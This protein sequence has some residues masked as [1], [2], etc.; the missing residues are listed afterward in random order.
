ME[1]LELY[2]AKL[3]AY[4][5]FSKKKSSKKTV[6]STSKKDGKKGKDEKFEIFKD[7][8][9]VENSALAAQQKTQKTEENLEANDKIQ[10]S[11]IPS[12]KLRSKK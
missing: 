1:K 7:E 8:E 4:H 2:S 6:Q 9:V 12:K 11:K 3:E 5:T 10:K